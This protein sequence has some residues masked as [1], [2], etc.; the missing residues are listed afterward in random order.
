MPKESASKEL[1][2]LD[3]LRA[4]RQKIETLDERLAS[5][6]E[7]RGA[8]D[9]QVY[10]RVHGDYVQQRAALVEEAQPLKAQGRSMFQELKRE[11][12]SMEAAFEE[13]RLAL[14][15]VNLRATLGEFDEAEAKTRRA[16]LDAQLGSKREARERAEARRASFLDAFGSLEELEPSSFAPPRSSTQ[17]IEKVPEPEPKIDVM[18]TG[19]M[20]AFRTDII[21]PVPAPPPAAPA[22]APAPPPAPAPAPKRNPDG[23][24]VFRPGRL[25]P[26][27]SEAGLAPT[28]LSLKPIAIGSDNICDVRLSQS[29]IARRQAE[30]TLGRAGFLLKDLAGGGVVKVNGVD[31]SEQLLSD[32]DQISVGSAQFLFRLS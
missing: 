21:E 14:E 7:K 30:I 28:T 11:L 31:V 24:L 16:S 12:E 2:V 22:P 17:P 5:M 20:R 1:G 15:E 13:H 18:A 23:T 8:V 3:Q 9:P 10:T 26:Q 25:H 19:S 4:L 29:G 6:A 32:G 27:N